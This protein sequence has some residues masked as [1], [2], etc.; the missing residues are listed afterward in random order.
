M[1]GTNVKRKIITNFDV[2]GNVYKV[3]ATDHAIERLA[4]RSLNR[5]YIASACLALGEKLETYNNS[6]KQIMIV[7]ATKNVSSVIAIEDYTIVVIT[8]LAKSNPYVKENT[9][10]E[11]FVS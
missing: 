7:D 1:E 4:K 8:V 2:N 6:G 5:Y 9:L 10:I 3:I 11:N